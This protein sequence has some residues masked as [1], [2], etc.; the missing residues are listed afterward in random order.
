MA[1]DQPFGRYLIN[2]HMPKGFTI[3][4]GIGKKSLSQ[5]MNQ[6]AR[7]D[8]GLYVNTI[9]NLKRLGDTLATQEGLSVG[10]DDIEPEYS[11]RDAI[12]RS[13]K[14]Q[15]RSATTDT[16]RRAIVEAA[17]GKILDSTMKHRGS[18]TQ[19]VKS[20]AR[21][22]PVQYMKTVGSPVYARDPKGKVAPWLIERSY[23]EGLSAADYYVAGNEAIMDTVKSQTSVSEP[24]ELGRILINNMSD[25]IVTEDDCG[26][27]NGIPMDPKNPDAVDRY[28]AKSV[29][30]FRA[31]TL[32]TSLNQPKLAKVS[33]RVLVRSPMMCEAGDGVCQKCQGLNENGNHQEIGTNVGIRAA[34]A[35]AEP[36]TQ[37]AL[38]AKHGVRTAQT[39]RLQ[40]SGLEGVRQIIESPKQF[41]N[42][43]T[44]STLDG[45]VG[46]VEKAP[47]G[48]HFVNIGTKQHYVTPNLQ[49][50]VKPG[51]Q[52]FAG[53]VLSE[54]IPKPDEV[55]KYKGLGAGRQYMVDTLKG[56]YQNQGKNLDQRHFELLAKGELNAVKILDDPGNNFIPGD[57]VNYNTL[58]ST[59]GRN[60]KE[61]PINKALGE[62]LGK[63]YLHYS[64]GTRVTPEV[65]RVLRKDKINSVMIAPRA[66]EV[67]F[68]MKPATRAPLLNPD[69]MARLAHRNLK[70][71]LQQAAHFGDVANIHGTSPIPA[72]AFGVE[73]G[74]GAQGRY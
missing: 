54:G 52:V 15:F 17:H 38:N 12:L 19:Q 56:I 48:G 46:R 33:R 69:W 45:K 49:V 71:T 35:M 65:A 3:N 14:Q 16:R 23:S 42:K 5:S 26:T 73:F 57:V 61:L 70:T 68:V 53:D 4:S 29:G 34:Q 25:L 11:K 24:G 1:T 6:L 47:Q 60:V 66:P 21:G 51:Q 13:A 2:Q 55:V 50:K 64:V 41:I 36:L 44:L 20:G 72:Y 27:N 40:V 59:L 30:P 31:G 8:P 22:N 9:S 10:L 63:E 32:I 67:E 43:A 7:Q 18:L 74:Q 58:R 62:T 37:F 28:L 39:D